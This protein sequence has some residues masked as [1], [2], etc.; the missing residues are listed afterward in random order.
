MMWL[1]HFKNRVQ[2]RDVHPFDAVALRCADLNKQQKHCCT[3]LHETLLYMECYMHA[4]KWPFLN[5]LTSN[6][7][8]FRVTKGWPT[9]QDSG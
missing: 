3:V 1:E 2:Q 6:I 7:K 4:F 5:L 9:A 8:N